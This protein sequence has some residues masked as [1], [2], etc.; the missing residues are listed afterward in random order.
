[1][2][3]EEY[4]MPGG[5]QPHG[6]SSMHG[7]PPP[8]TPIKKSFADDRAFEVE[9]TTCHS[10]TSSS[11]AFCDVEAATA[12]VTPDIR[13]SIFSKNS[14]QRSLH[15]PHQQQHQYGSRSQRCSPFENAAFHY[16]VSQ[17]PSGASTNG[18]L[19]THD[20]RK[21]GSLSSSRYCVGSVRHPSLGKRD[22]QRDCH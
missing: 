3:A 8:P 2:D 15:D 21:G 1:M 22:D 18:T 19:S 12:A 6:E 16:H 4:L 14:M 7:T 10:S 20:L 13:Q 5:R 9:P 17:Y 11:A